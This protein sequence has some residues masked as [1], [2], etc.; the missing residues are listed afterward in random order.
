MSTSTLSRLL[1]PLRSPLRHAA[2]A[3]V[4]RTEL[5]VI[6]PALRPADAAFVAEWRA[7][8]FA[9]AGHTV[10]LA[11]ASPF[12]VDRAPDAWVAALHGF[13]WLR[14]IPQSDAAAGED[15]R[16]L[17]AAWLAK[18]RP[19]VASRLP[20]VARRVLSWLA[21][22]DLL[23]DT[24][25]TLFYDAVLSAFMVD[26]NALQRQWRG[27]T[28]GGDRVCVL[29]AL[30]HAGLCIADAAPLRL[31][32]EAALQDEWSRAHKSGIDGARAVLRAPDAL[33]DLLLDLETLRL[34]YG[35]R[36]LPVPDSVTRMKAAMTETLGDLMLGHGRLAQLRSAR[37]VADARARLA[38]VKRHASVAATPSRH[39]IDAGIARLIA[40]DTSVIADVGAPLQSLDALGL[41][42]SCGNAALLTHD[43]YCRLHIDATQVAT[44]YGTLLFPATALA[45]SNASNQS[46]L[47]QA[48]HSVV[49]DV[50]DPANLCL[51]ATHA[52]HARRGI[53]H[54][55]RVSV[56]EQG[57]HIAVIDELRPLI[58]GAA[59]AAV[60]FGVRLVL[61][62]TV[63]VQLGTLQDRLDLTL[64]N[65]QRWHFC[66][67]S[68]QISVESAV[69]RDGL[70]DVQSL[71]ILVYSNAASTRIV[72]WQLTRL[73]L[74]G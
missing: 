4:H 2:Y 28:T 74:T 29:I 40:G 25:D 47:Q 31:K 58:G 11:G 55:R 39:N 59:D 61:H 20:I 63:T 43:G 64:S 15:T 46:A 5:S 66:A 33:A 35:M 13:E 60:P 37:D 70:H 18:K 16:T 3:G 34:T 68:H 42:V 38:A 23:L 19:P 17:V 32:A 1:R 49:V 27:L 71:Q 41:E 72:T 62:P 56:R 57:R 69:F 26:V 53:V 6:P 45:S 12:D 8:S 48:S 22:A 51:D 24:T 10:E 36:S 65:G 67:A 73:D 50:A 9:L 21:H 44:G 14:N 7:G 30:A 54:R 52:G